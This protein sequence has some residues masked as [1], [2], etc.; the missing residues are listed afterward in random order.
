MT[1]GFASAVLLLTGQATPSPAIVVPE[2]WGEFSRR[3]ARGGLNEIV[4]LGSVD[5]PPGA[6]KVYWAR[7]SGSAIGTTDSLRCPALRRIVE[8]I[9]QL[10]PPKLVPGNP[11]VLIGDGTHYSISLHSSFHPAYASNLDRI[12][13]ESGGGP[14]AHWTD[15]A[16]AALQGCWSPA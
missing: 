1:L 13:I 12:T 11:E 2:P 8:S 5:R 10:Q 9:G 7:R 6:P 14:L 4:A 3:R 16:L 15:Q